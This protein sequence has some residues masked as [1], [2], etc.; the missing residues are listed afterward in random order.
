MNTYGSPSSKPLCFTIIAD[1]AHRLDER[2]RVVKDR[3]VVQAEEVA[4]LVAVR[5]V[6]LDRL[7]LV[8]VLERA[9]VIQPWMFDVQVISV[10]PSQ[11]PIVS[12]YQ[13]GTSAPSRGTAPSMLNSRP[14]WMLVMK[15]RAT[16]A[17]ICT[18]DGVTMM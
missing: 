10:S 8:R 11:K 18:S 3:L 17:M 5:R 14:T 12:P 1:D 13:R 2:L 7:H 15:L 9:C 4:V 16:P 6:D